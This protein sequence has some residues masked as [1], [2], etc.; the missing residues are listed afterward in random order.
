[1]ISDVEVN[2]E[3]GAY[4]SANDRVYDWA[5]AFLNSF[6]AFNPTL[7]LFLIPFNEECDRLLTLQD[8]YQ[9]EIYTDASFDRLEAIGQAFELGHTPT[10]PH[11]FRR[12]SV[13]WGPC[14][15]FIYLDARQLV[16][17]NLKAAIS[18]LDDFSFDL[19]HFDCD[20]DQV[21]EP[22][23]L[24]RNLLHRQKARGFNSGRWIARKGLFTLEELEQL[25]AEAL[26]VRDQLNKRNT[27]QAFIN[28]CCDMK[29]VHYRHIA[30]L[31]G[32]SCHNSWASQPGH[33]YQTCGTFRRWHYG[34]QNHRK[35]L[36]ILHW[37]GRKKSAIMP[38]RSLWRKFFLEKR[39]WLEK[40]RTLLS[41]VFLWFPLAVWQ[42][43]RKN[44][45]INTLYHFL[46]LG[47]KENNTD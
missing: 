45:K 47:L 40:T 16:L 34:G 26:T 17:A 44:R 42:A 37:A 38:E 46:N 33:V 13:F 31:L 39:S 15:R 20:I 41:D 35:Q 9:F 7:K 30:D 36:L 4:F 8:T 10:G 1:M 5:I 11:W 18:A 2:R 12:Y 29:P 6:R 21:Y 27:D 32:N 3:I 19:L 24:K 14:D 22:G 25:A 28:Y 23:E 43:A